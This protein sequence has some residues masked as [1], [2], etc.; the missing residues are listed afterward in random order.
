M[1]NNKGYYSWIHSLNGS[2]MQAHKKGLEMLAE[3]KARKITNQERMAQLA[4]QMQAPKAVEHGKP[5]VDPAVIRIAAQELAKEPTTPTSIDLAGG[6]VGAYVDIRRTKQAEKLAD[7]NKAQGPVDAEPHEPGDGEDGVM[8]DPP[9][10][11]VPDVTVAAQARKETEDL[12]R[13]KEW[14]E[15]ED[16]RHWSDYTGRT[17]EKMYESVSDKINKFL[18]N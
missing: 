13:E 8:A 16:A 7:M 12:E 10:T 1:K 18:R 5:D 15:S 11:R 3:E 2:A 4:A 6:D 9:L 14:E 17:G